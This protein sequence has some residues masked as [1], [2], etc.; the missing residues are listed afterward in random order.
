MRASWIKIEP[1]FKDKFLEE[2]GMQAGRQRSSFYKPKNVSDCQQ[3]NTRN[4]ERGTEHILPHGLWQELTLVTPGFQT[5]GL[6]P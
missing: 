4:E 6:Q 5:S 2:K 1:K 3:P